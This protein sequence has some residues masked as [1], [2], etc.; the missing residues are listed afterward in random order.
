MSDRA[1]PA[2]APRRGDRRRGEA[3]GGFEL[4]YRLMRRDGE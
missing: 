4:D 3:M 1:D 2:S